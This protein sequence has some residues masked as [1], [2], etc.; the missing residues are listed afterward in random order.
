MTIKRLSLERSKWEARG[1]GGSSTP[2]GASPGAPSSPG[3]SEGMLG[4]H[5]GHGNFSDMFSLYGIRHPS[6]HGKL[7]LWVPKAVSGLMMCQ[8]R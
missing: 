6:L 2:T 4:M 8:W 5:L 1:A 3:G 7:F